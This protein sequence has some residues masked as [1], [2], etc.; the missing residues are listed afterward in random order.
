N[1]CMKQINALIASIVVGMSASVALA[2]AGETSKANAPANAATM[3]P[4]DNFVPDPATVQREGPAYRYPQAGWIVLHIEGEPYERGWQHGKLLAPEI[5]EYV[6]AY[7]MM[8]SSKAPG[9]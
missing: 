5:A 6:K 8:Q 2:G 9:D 7:A 1:F 3:L 4:S